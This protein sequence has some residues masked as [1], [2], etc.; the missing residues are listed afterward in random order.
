MV[1]CWEFTAQTRGAENVIRLS[2]DFTD[3]GRV[4]DAG[5]KIGTWEIS[6]TN[7]LVKFLD[8]KLGNVTFG[9]RTANH[10]FGRTTVNGKPR[11]TC[12]LH[13]VQQVAI[14]RTEGLGTLTFYSNGR[15]NRPRHEAGAVD[16]HWCF[17]KKTLRVGH[18]ETDVSADGKRLPRIK[19]VIV[20]GRPLIPPRS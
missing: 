14:Y 2:V 18:H 1:D 9:R 8:E 20:S 10:L 16:M 12:Q 13:R 17:D 3:D 5:R 6:G 19:G 4:I 11:W 7:V 15:I